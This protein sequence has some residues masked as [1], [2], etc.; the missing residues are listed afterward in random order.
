MFPKQEIFRAVSARNPVV[1]IA[2][3][4]TV[5]DIPDWFVIERLLYFK[6][7]VNV[8]SILNIFWGVLHFHFSR[9]FVESGNTYKKGK[10]I[11]T[12]YLKQAFEKSPMKLV[13][14]IKT[15]TLILLG[16]ED[17]RVPMSPGLFYYRLLK[18][19]KIPTK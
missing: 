19:R 2:S 13:D 9:N 8:L 15:P 7:V 3:M 14:N 6:L 1:D 5:T 17:R 18:A 16:T 11:S 12:E 4:T 10:N